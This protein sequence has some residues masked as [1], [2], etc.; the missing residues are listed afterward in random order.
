MNVQQRIGGSY[1]NIDVYTDTREVLAKARIN[2]RERGLQDWFVCDIDAHHVESVSWKEIVQYIEDPVIRDNAVRYQ[3]ERIGAPP[4]GLNGDLGLRYQSVG[5]RI[6]HQ[7]DL[8]EK[9]TETD[10]H[11]DVVLTRRAMDSL[12]ID[13][14]VVFP[15]PML[16]LGMHPQ[17]DMEVWLSRAYNRWTA[18]RLLDGDDRIKTFAVLPFNTPKE[19]ER[20]VEDFGDHRGVIG[21]CVTSTRH[22]PVHHNDYMRLY[23]IL[24][25]RNKPLAFHAGYHWQDPSLATV[26]RFLGMHALGFVWCNMVHMTNW[27]LNGLPERFPGLKTVWV[28]SGLAWVPFLMQRLDDQF[29][30]RQS[31]APLLKRMPS[32]YMRENCWYTTQPMEISHPKALQ[33]TLEMINAKTQ[34]LFASDWPHFDFDLPQMICDLPFLD[35]ES[36]RNILGLNAA[37]LFNLEPK[38]RKNLW[39]QGGAGAP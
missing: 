27:I 31:E 22:K 17:T 2:A 36:K 14:M 4:Y 37:R 32:D 5:G 29:L 12:G 16:F 23:A 6:P 11:R 8:R 21:F 30:M 26:N 15:T 19:A 7:D 9:V 38:I 39:A 13:N 33:N 24:Q 18:E 35:E 28:E 20:V 10:V 34:L 3:S 1:P 25:E